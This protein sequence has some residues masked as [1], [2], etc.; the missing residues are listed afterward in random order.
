M[1]RLLLVLF[2][3]VACAACQTDPNKPILFKSPEQYIDWVIT[4]RGYIVT[5]EQYLRY[6]HQDEV[7]KTLSIA[8][9]KEYGSLRVIFYSYSIGANVYRKIEFC[10]QVD[11][12]LFMANSYRF[13]SKFVDKSEL[14]MEYGATRDDIA[15]VLRAAYNWQPDDDKW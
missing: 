4:P 7:A 15:E 5:E 2:T 8:E 12:Y 10:K 14:A 1:R 3:F 9:V 6:K 11:E 13:A